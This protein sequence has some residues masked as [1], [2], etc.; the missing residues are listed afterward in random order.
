MRGDPRDPGSFNKYSYTGGDPINLATRMARTTVIPTTRVQLR[1]RPE[2]HSVPN[3]ATGGF[4]VSYSLTNATTA[5]LPGSAN[6][7]SITLNT[8]SLSSIG[9]GNPVA[10]AITLLHELGHVY[11]DL[12]GATS[13]LIQ[14]DFENPD[15]SKANTALVTEACFK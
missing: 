12:F 8:N 14:N 11:D 15:L 9:S 1:C 10:A 4:A 5:F 13:T 7:P 2:Y 3:T 6:G